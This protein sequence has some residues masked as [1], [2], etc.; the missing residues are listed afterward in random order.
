MKYQGALNRGIVERPIPLLGN[1]NDQDEYITQQRMAKLQ[2]LLAAHNVEVGDWSGLAIALAVAHVPGF[3]V[4][5][6]R[7]RKSVWQEYDRAELYLD[8]QKVIEDSGGA[9]T[10]EEAIK[11][12]CRL[13]RWLEILKPMMLGAIV[14]QYHLADPRVV[15]AMRDAR[16]YERIRRGN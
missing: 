11:R 15:E 6:P 8:V 9:M 5:Q 12:V 13:D 16:E 3:K 7:G 2:L 10:I 4:V 14:K 1:P